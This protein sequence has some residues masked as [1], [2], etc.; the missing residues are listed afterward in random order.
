MDSYTVLAQ[1]YDRLTADVDYE[2]WADYVERHFRKLKRPV[3]SVVELACG[4]G[5]LT[6]LLARR[7]YSV[8]GVDLSPDMLTIAEQKC[9]G[10]DVTLLCR[11]MSRLALPPG[12]PAVQTDAVICCLDSVNYV[13]RPAA[14]RR[15]FQRV[16]K[17]LAPGGLFLFDVKTPAALEG[18]DGRTYLD[19]DDDLYCVWRADW[20]PR[21]R[22]CAY[23]LDLFLRNKD[24]LWE[25]GG[26]YH[27]EYAWTMDELD[28]FLREVGFRQVRQYGDK[29]MTAP[30]EEAQRVFFAARR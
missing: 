28:G 10:L 22:V 20:Y 27:E 14:L 8:I 23:G 6:C 9:R 19:E 30:K 4:T 13:T 29:V 26:E 21:R 7:G 11:D 24:G 15:T 25:R 16:Y 2:K 17:A 3:H 12:Q 1:G 18:A 5:S